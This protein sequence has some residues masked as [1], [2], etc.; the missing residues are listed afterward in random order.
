M[1]IVALDLSLTETGWAGNDGYGTWPSKRLRGHERLDFIMANLEDILPRPTHAVFIEGFSFGSKG[2]AIYEIGGLGYLVRHQLWKW[3]VPYC[4]VPPSTLKK[5]ATSNGRAT[6][7]DMID[8]ARM[9][10]YVGKNDNEADAYLLWQMGLA[11]LTGK[12]PEYESKVRWVGGPVVEPR[13]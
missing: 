9:N 8:G 3:G 7:F 4:E 5:W 1:N 6:K 13:R 11:L 2:R 10:G 12:A